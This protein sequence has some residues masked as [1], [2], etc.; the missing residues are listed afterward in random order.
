M[1]YQELYDMRVNM[2]AYALG[3]SKKPYQG[4][5]LAMM[6]TYFDHPRIRAEF[7][8]EPGI[9]QKMRLVLKGARIATPRI[10]KLLASK[11]VDSN[12]YQDATTYFRYIQ[13]IVEFVQFFRDERL[14]TIHTV[15]PKNG[16]VHTNPRIASYQFRILLNNVSMEKLRALHNSIG[17]LKWGTTRWDVD[18]APL[19]HAEASVGKPYANNL[20][21]YT[22]EKYNATVVAQLKQQA[23]AHKSYIARL[24]KAFNAKNPVRLPEN[25]KITI[26]PESISKEVILGTAYLDY[27]NQKLSTPVHIIPVCSQFISAVNQ[28]NIES[29]ENEWLSK[30]WDDMPER[31][32]ALLPNPKP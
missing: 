11:Q 10:S 21:L 2:Y 22:N 32:K 30:H 1:D 26:V 16:M 24:L 7:G 5:I 12:F 19:S 8:N 14:T 4:T 25:P 6:N 3:F 23:N 27:K 31:F 13:A 29:R 9:R 15:T 18:Q 28:V 20:F 17:V